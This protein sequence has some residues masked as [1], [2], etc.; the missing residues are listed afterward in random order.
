M[1]DSEASSAGSHVKFTLPKPYTNW[2][3][4]LVNSKIRLMVF[5]CATKTGKSIAGSSR[6]IQESFSS[7]VNQEALF[8]VIAPTYSLSKI[9]YEY[10]NRFLPE[11]MPQ[12]ILS[13]KYDEAN[14][15]WKRFTPNRSDHSGTLTWKH[16]KSKIICVHG[17]NPEVTIEGARVYGNCFD[18]AAKLKR[19]VFD[20]AMSTTTQTGG[21]NCL[22]GTPRGKNWYYDLYRECLE[23]MDWAHRTGGTLEMFAAQART[24]DNPFVPKESIERARKHLPDRIFRQL[25]MA[26]F[27][28]D[29]TVFI[30][31]KDCI[32]G[33][34]I[35]ID[36]SH[37]VQIWTDPECDTRSVV[38]GTDWAKREDYFVSVAIDPTHNPPKVAGFIRTT[39]VDYTACVR[40][41]YQFTKKFKEVHVIRHDRTGVGDVLDEML[42]PLGI[43]VEP[44][45]FTNATKAHMVDR[46]LVALQSKDVIIPNWKPLLDEHDTYDATVTPMG[47]PKYGAISGSHD[48]IVTA[49]MLA[50]SAAYE[51]RDRHLEVK[52]L[53]DLNKKDIED[54][55]FSRMISMFEDDD[56]VGYN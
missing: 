48:D 16:N 24:I 5:P 29:G 40:L 51:M 44:V 17:D 30:G 41:L 43:F 18:E 25:F 15:A 28:D 6:L 54:D 50:Y 39:H 45:V 8:R 23:H 4:M 19:Q 52:V 34:R 11:N 37:K 13:S 53:E 3:K 31:Y 21:W 27:L 7:G 26:E 22:Y 56:D 32:F 49:I 12:T 14:A 38:I 9:T 46:Y 36:E 55:H 47:L 33:E 20:S 1:R 10:L 2:Q 42:Q 35:E